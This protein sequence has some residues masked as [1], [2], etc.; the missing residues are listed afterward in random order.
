MLRHT[1]KRLGVTDT[2]VGSL[3]IRRLGSG[4]SVAL[5]LGA[6]HA[7]DVTLLS[8][9]FHGGGVYAD[10]VSTPEGGLHF[11][12][13]HL[14]PAKYDE[15]ILPVGLSMSA[16]LFDWVA[17]S[18]GPSPEKPDG[19]VLKLDVDLA[20]RTE[21]GFGGAL[22]TETVVPTLDG[23][24]KDA[25]LL[26]IRAQPEV[27]HT[28]VGAGKVKLAASKQKLWRTSAFRL[29]I[30]GVD[31]TKV[32]RIDT[33]SVSRPPTAVSDGAGGVMLTAGNVV[34]PN[35]HVTLPLAHAQSWFDWHEDFVVAGN[36]GDHL[37]RQGVLS[38]L[39]MDF[40][41]ELS[42]I[43]LHHLGIVRLQAAPGQAAEV[44]AEIYC[45]EMVL[46]RPG[47]TP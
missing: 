16:G 7:G 38:F 4:G 36:N 34:F 21:T 30:D 26:V 1:G 12:K 43:D 23:S 27:L 24:S 6:P 33:F 37:E 17:G 25:G 39:S 31:C 10:V 8:E 22:I 42:R 11:A 14:G 13:K 9:G 3:R 2:A 18:W 41:T 35:L 40:K 47:G 44:T 20:I 15:L 45:E 29:E 46:G 28:H 5:R 19:A 32:R